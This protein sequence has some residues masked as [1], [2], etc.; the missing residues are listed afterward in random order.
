MMDEIELSLLKDD[1]EK[2]PK[3]PQKKSLEL[4]SED[5]KVKGYKVNIQKPIAYL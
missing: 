1:M 5:S 4:T 3:N 2:I